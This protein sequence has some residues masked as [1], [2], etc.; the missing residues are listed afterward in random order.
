MTRHLAHVHARQI[1]DS[2]GNPTV[3]VDVELESGAFGRAAVPVGRLDRR[4]RGASSCATAARSGAARAS[5]KAVGERQRRDRRRRCAGSTPPTSAALDQRLIELDGTPN[6]GRLG[7]NAI[8]GVSLAVAQGGRRRR[9]L[10]LFRYLGGEEARD[11]ARADAERDQRRRA[12]AELDRPAGVHA[13]A[14]RRGHASPRPCAIGAEVFHALKALLHE[15]GLST[16]VGDEGGFAPDLGSSED[17]IE[18]VLEAAERAGHRD[19]VA[20]ALDP[21]STE[22]YEDGALPLRGQ[23][24]ATATGW[25]SFYAGL[26]ERYPLVSIEDGL[27]EDDWDAWRALTERARRPAAARRRRPLRHERRAPAARNRRR[28]RQRDPREGQPDRD[29][30]RDARHD[31]ARA[32]ERLRV[33][34]VA[35]LRR[36]RGHDDRRPRRRHGRGPDQD[37]RALAHATAS[38]STTSC[39]ASRRSS[40]RARCI[41]GWD[42][43]PRPALGRVASLRWHG[44]RSAYLAARRSS[45]PSGRPARRR[46][47]R[48]RSSRPGMDAARLN[49]S[50]G[51]H[52]QHRDWARARPR[53]AGASSAGRSR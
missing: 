19:R 46:S 21:A 39:S 52:D 36:D 45:P 30:H 8:L 32:R 23:R 3:E 2:R 51:T 38:R 6:K 33:R 7:A 34:D 24:R 10:S 49:L 43:F 35:P 14:G 29:A 22:L 16:G 12:R 20:I 37:R 17:A 44:G 31:R 48:R 11:A 28:R 5:R 27:A 18:A 47:A 1:L 41:P 26:V 4:A 53:G 50:H 42:A 15:R 40:A 9:R 13:R 25:P